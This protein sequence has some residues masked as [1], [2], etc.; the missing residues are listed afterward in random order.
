M[1][2][3]FKNLLIFKQILMIRLLLPLYTIFFYSPC[4]I[5]FLLI[6]SYKGVGRSLR[7]WAK[8]CLWWIGQPYTVE[9]LENIDK[10]K[11]YIVVSNHGSIIDIPL[12]GL[13]F[14]TPISW[15]MKDV[16]LKVP[17]TSTMFKLGVGIPIARTKPREA[18]AKMFETVDRL[19]K[20]MDPNIIIFPEGT[21]TKTGEMSDFKRGYVPL[22]RQYEMDI[23]PVTLCGVYN[24]LSADA[25]LPNPD[26]N[27]KII[28]HPPQRYEDIKE[29]TDKEINKKMQ[30]IVQ[31]DYYA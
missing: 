21:R 20:K 1:K 12:T 3:L 25:S 30:E 16:L 5:F 18:Q 19:K 14:G 2:T 7:R 24:F 6:H 29:F 15:V 23:L 22:V 17:I 10:N 13:L 8:G 11:R 28:V 26:T 4:V 31:K 27:M 9:G